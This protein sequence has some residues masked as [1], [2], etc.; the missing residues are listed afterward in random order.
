M[1]MRMDKL[2]SNAVGISNLIDKSLIIQNWLGPWR[3]T[4]IVHHLDFAKEHK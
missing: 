1:V 4:N 2:T 3:F